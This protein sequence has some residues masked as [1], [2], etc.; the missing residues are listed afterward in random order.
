MRGGALLVAALCALSTR[1]AAQENPRP[2]A[3]GPYAVLFRA[4]P[5]REALAEIVRLTGIDL[6]YTDGLVEG[7]RASCA[8]RGASAE[9]LLGC[10]LDGT[11]LDYVR[12]SSGAYV[13]VRAVREMPA[14]GRVAGR[15]VDA[16]TGQPLPAATVFLADARTATIRTG[17]IQRNMKANVVAKTLAASERGCHVHRLD[18]GGNH[19]R[20]ARQ[21]VRNGG[22][23]PGF[24]D[25]MRRY[26]RHRAITAR[27]F[28]CALRPGFDTRQAMRDRTFARLVIT[29][30]EVK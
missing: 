7:E 13:L 22:P 28:M 18:I 2:E 26:R 23:K 11:G 1:A 10:A 9:A 30:L 5:L 29:E 8:R 6:V 12:S 20:F 17:T 4:A 16:E 15:V 3:A 21:I 25:E 19:L 24:G 14:R 27:Q